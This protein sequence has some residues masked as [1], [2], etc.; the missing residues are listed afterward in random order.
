MNKEKVK[1]KN[2]IIAVF[3]ILLLGIVLFSLFFLLQYPTKHNDIIKK[4]SEMYSVPSS[5]IASVIKIE[6]GYDSNA[7][8]PA[9]AVGLMQILPATAFDMA[10]RIGIDVDYADLFDVDTNIRLGTY[11]LKYLMDMFDKNTTNTLSAY[12]WGLNNV[13]T[14]MLKGNT[15]GYGNLTNIPNIETQ[16]YLKKY[17]KALYFYRDI[18]GYDH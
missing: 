3:S 5:M 9:G 6:S 16:N 17:K 12:N 1:N 8:S 15:D 11:Y 4:Y 18:F 2:I 13:R 10:D 7:V 14:W